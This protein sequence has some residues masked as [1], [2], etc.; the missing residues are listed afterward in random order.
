M[1]EIRTDKI[2]EK[3]YGEKK[4]KH[5]NRNTEIAEKFKKEEPQSLNLNPLLNKRRRTEDARNKEVKD[6]I[7]EKH[8]GGKEDKRENRKRGISGRVADKVSDKRTK[9]ME[10]AKN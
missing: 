2:E 1:H 9:H 5:E 6:K 4:R 7:E 3:Q 10:D 8:D